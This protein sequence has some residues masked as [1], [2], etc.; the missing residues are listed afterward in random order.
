MNWTETPARREAL[1]PSRVPKR[2]STSRFGVTGTYVAPKS[3]VAVAEAAGPV[4]STLVAVTRNVYDEWLV[5]PLNEH[6]SGAGSVT[7][8]VVVGGEVVTV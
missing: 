3:G 2:E 1:S 5:R 7:V 6:V 8:H 4:P